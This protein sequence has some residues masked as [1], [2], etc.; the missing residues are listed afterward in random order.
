MAENTLRANKPIVMALNTLEADKAPWFMCLSSLVAMLASSQMRKDIIV[1][2]GKM[3][4]SFSRHLF[5]GTETISCFLFVFKV[6]RILQTN[7]PISPITI[8]NITRKI[9]KSAADSEG[10]STI[11][12]AKSVMSLL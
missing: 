3:I 7:S 2:I 10:L 9:L 12:P 1:I 5:T 4:V 8:R 6:L 11:G